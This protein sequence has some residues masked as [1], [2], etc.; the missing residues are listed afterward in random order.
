[1]LRS[2]HMLVELAKEFDIH[3]I[4]PIR[5]DVLHGL[6]A[7]IDEGLADCQ[8]ALGNIC[9]D[10]ALIE[11]GIGDLK[12]RKLKVAAQS[13][14]NGRAYSVAWFYSRQMQTAVADALARNRYA[15][16]HCDTISLLQYVPDDV[17]AP[18]V[19]NN[20]NIESDMLRVR[21]ERAPSFV[22]RRYFKLEAERMEA[23]ERAVA[24]R[25]SLHLTCSDEDGERL[26]KIDPGLRVVV[27]PN[28]VDTT[29][30]QPIQFEES[31][32]SLVFVGGQSWYPNRDAMEF[33]ATDVWPLLIEKRPGLT[34][35]LIGK[36]PSPVVREL[37][38]RD[39]RFRVHG[40]VD[41]IRLMV[42]KATAFVCPIRDGGG[43]KLKILDAM[44]MGK[45]IVAHPH[46]V[47]GIDVRDGTSVVLA[48]T[49][50][51]FRDACLRV[52]EDRELRATLE[53]EGRRVVEER[54]SS[55]IIGNDLR[56]HYHCLQKETI[57]G[58]ATN[59]S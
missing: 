18:I 9:S 33:F 39:K 57:D 24:G 16:V 38:A 46:S 27:I 40:F 37:A 35:D 56:R 32:E 17:G 52:I 10:V 22:M 53:S 42:G 36:N 43:T 3:M 34:F 59:L 1:M 23:Y 48:S 51:Q 4:S 31:S 58:A 47:D 45:A 12:W 13:L 14:V 25:A 44:A 6:Y 29:Y 50:E 41:D 11:A 7:D 20:H 28:G 19:V 55:T 15:I 8:G 26:L 2:Y 21:A 30:F 49:A 5:R 54:Y